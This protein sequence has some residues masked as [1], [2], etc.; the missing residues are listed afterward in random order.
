MRKIYIKYIKLVFYIKLFAKNL[1]N[2]QKV[3]IF[4]SDICKLFNF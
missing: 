3:C 1:F 4:A 2:L